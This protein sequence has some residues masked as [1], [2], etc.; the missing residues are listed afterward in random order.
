MTSRSKSRK[1]PKL[2]K[3]DRVRKELR[4]QRRGRDSVEVARVKDL[5]YGEKV[6]PGGRR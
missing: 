6:V 3:I 4:N 2:T 1:T 5:L